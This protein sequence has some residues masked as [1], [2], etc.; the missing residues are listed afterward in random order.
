MGKKGAG[1][2][3]YVQYLGIQEASEW[4]LE[5]VAQVPYV[6]AL[7]ASRRQQTPV[8]WSH[9]CLLDLACVDVIA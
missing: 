7:L 2:M 1:G 6:T 8:R 3:P 5:R 9:L 4:I